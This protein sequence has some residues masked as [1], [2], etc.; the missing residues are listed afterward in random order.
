MINSKTDV[1]YV[2]EDVSTVKQPLVSVIVA[3]YRR[4][5][6]L[7]RALAS[8]A[9]QTY[10]DTEIIVVD[11]NGDDGWNKKIQA[12]VDKTRESCRFPITLKTMP[13]NS[14]APEA[15]NC[16]VQSAKGEYIT[17]L[18]DDDV[19][20]KEKVERQVR[21]MIDTGAD[22]GLTD[23]DLYNSEDK[24]VDRRVRSYL[25]ETDRDSLLR[26][27]ILYHMTGTDTLMFRAEYL[28]EIGGFPHIAVGDE[29]YLMM[30]AI[31]HE[32]KITYMPECCVKAYVHTG[33]DSGLSSGSGK[34]EG[35][36]NLYLAKEKYMKYLSKQDVK[37]VKLRH[38]AVLAYANLRMKNYPAFI[39]CAGRAFLV[40][41]T[42]ALKIRK[43]H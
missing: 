18:D 14:G 35:E 27:H 43:E 21:D 4:D 39:E 11:D 1:N 9:E 2:T 41:P 32:G 22:Y 7:E 31:L 24:L 13:E 40:S 8:I 36:N 19:Y 5:V 6:F 37:Y 10:D 16:G 23:L 26:Y 12:I 42:G 3:T 28:K 33:D 34:I 30:E 29:F 25:K 15:R 20:L 17:F 38:W